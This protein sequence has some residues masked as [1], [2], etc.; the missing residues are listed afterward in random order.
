[1]RIVCEQAAGR[2]PVLAAAPQTDKQK[3]DYLTL[4]NV[5]RCILSDFGFVVIGV[6]EMGARGS[7]QFFVGAGEPTPAFAMKVPPVSPSLG[8]SR[9]LASRHGNPTDSRL[10]SDKLFV[11]LSISKSESDCQVT[12][13]RTH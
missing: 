5:L 13:Y 6:A 12:R 10:F 8:A 1:V 9:P 4:Q 11:Q 7:T 2:V 3:I